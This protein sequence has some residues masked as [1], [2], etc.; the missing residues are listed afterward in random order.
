M[1]DPTKEEISSCA[2]AMLAEIKQQRDNA[3]D[4]VVTL[5]GRLAVVEQQLKEAR[6][7]D[8]KND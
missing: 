2:D 8:S 5:K 6:K 4:T 7:N 3:L 1:S